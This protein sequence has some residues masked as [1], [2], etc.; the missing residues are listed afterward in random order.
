[1]IYDIGKFKNNNIIINNNIK[2][3]YEFVPSVIK[4]IIYIL[5]KEYF[6][7]NDSMFNP[8]RNILRE[9]STH[10]FYYKYIDNILE[11]KNTGENK[12][13]TDDKYYIFIKNNKFMKIYPL[14]KIDYFYNDINNSKKLNN[15]E[16]EEILSSINSKL[17]SIKNIKGMK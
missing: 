2:L 4:G 17:D 7:K 13:N 8:K 9:Y 10:S 11:L 3:D 15:D 1:M 6:I 14:S 5:P 16:K 12:F